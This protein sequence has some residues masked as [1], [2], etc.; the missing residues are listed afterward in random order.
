MYILTEGTFQASHDY[1]DDNDHDNNHH[2]HHDHDQSSAASFQA[3]FL[4]RALIRSSGI[5]IRGDEVQDHRQCGRGQAAHR[6]V[7]VA[8]VSSPHTFWTKRKE[9]SWT[10]QDISSQLDSQSQLITSVLAAVTS[11]NVHSVV[12]LAAVTSQQLLDGVNGSL[13]PVL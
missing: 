1:H 11:L 5:C 3:V 7:S 2:D 10:I 6:Q 13:L 4:Q 12:R 8:P 9:N